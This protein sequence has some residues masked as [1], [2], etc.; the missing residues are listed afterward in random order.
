MQN[1]S[2]KTT[3]PYGSEGHNPDLDSPD[4]YSPDAYSPEA[5]N[6]DGFGHA[7][8]DISDIRHAKTFGYQ[9]GMILSPESMLDEMPF[10]SQTQPDRPKLTPLVLI[11]IALTLAGMLL[12]LPWLGWTGAGMTLLLS[13]RLVWPE[14]REIIQELLL[15]TWAAPWV[16]SLGVGVAI[17]A[18]VQ[19][20]GFGQGTLQFFRVVNWDAVGALAETLGAVGQISIAVLAVYIAWRQYVISKALTEQQNRL[21]I[22]Q[23]MITQQQTID[24]YFQG[25]SDLV[26]DDEGLLEDWPQERAI[27]EGRTAAILSSVNADGKAKVIRFLARSKLL[28]P[29]KRD[30]HLGRAILDGRGGYEEDRLH[31]V[32]VIDLGVMLAKANLC[33]TDLRWTDL[34]ESNL[35]YADLRNADLVKS[36]LSR[37][38]LFGANLRGA[39]VMGVRFHYGPVDTASPRSRTEPP[40]YIT[41]EY[42]GA[43][44]EEIDFTG[45]QRMSEEQRQYC[46]AWCGEK[47]RGTIPGGCGEIKNQL[48]R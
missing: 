46:C 1:G 33:N 38:I 44:V 40:N 6:A 43:V 23:N 48:G 11:A 35:I 12:Q 8:A 47:S 34:S 45:V 27:A 13:V 36:N 24:A 37:S 28:T 22:Q 9:G 39:D 7:W 16:A 26:L 32:R 17:A 31:G 5:Y 30:G 19:F 3:S 42:T 2:S 25:V 18:L 20:S 29:L 10:Q 4:A 15:D 21:T 14:L 41:G